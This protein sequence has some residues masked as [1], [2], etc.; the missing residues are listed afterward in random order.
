M[1]DLNSVT[2]NNMSGVA[3][4]MTTKLINVT[5]VNKKYPSIHVHL[6]TATKCMTTKP[7]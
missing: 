6:S 7:V 1:H 5:T 4:C 3:K 2:L